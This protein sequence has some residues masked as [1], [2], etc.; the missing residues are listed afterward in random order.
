MTQRIRE[1]LDLDRS[2]SASIPTRL[3]TDVNT[4]VVTCSYCGDAYYVDEDTFSSI[5]RAIGY[6]PD[7]VFTCPRCE[8][9]GT[10]DSRR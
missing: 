9:E 10:A 5:H 3:R 8:D 2:E 4:Q 1:E 7:N 6:D